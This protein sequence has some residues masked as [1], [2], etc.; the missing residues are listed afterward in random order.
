MEILKATQI[1]TTGFLGALAILG[2]FISFIIT[3]VSFAIDEPKIA[4][5]WGIIFII[6]L[7]GIFG[8]SS[9]TIDVP[10]GKWAYTVEITEPTKYHELIDKGY[11]FKKAYDNKEI[12]VITG[13]ELK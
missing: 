9:Y 6:C 7:I 2:A 8:F 13:D 11:E 5:I 4:I 10:T 12:Y 3:I 1:T